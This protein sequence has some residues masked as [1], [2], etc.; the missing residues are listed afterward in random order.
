VTNQELPY[1][2][3]ILSQLLFAAS[4]IL[5]FVKS[6]ILPRHSYG[7]CLFDIF[8]KKMLLTLTG[9]VLAMCSLSLFLCK[10]IVFGLKFNWHS[11]VFYRHLYVSGNFWLRHKF[12][13]KSLFLGI[14]YDLP[15]RSFLQN[16]YFFAYCWYK[17]PGVLVKSCIYN[18]SYNYIRS[19]LLASLVRLSRKLKHAQWDCV[20]FLRCRIRALIEG[21]YRTTSWELTIV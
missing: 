19:R 20:L 8:D 17:C 6:V 2:L 15:L 4:R 21:F 5:R 14:R 18:H 10:N 1:T 9:R 11:L 13:L 12:S 3:V 7:S 16:L